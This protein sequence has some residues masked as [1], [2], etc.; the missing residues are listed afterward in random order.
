MKAMYGIEHQNGIIG[1]GL[2]PSIFFE[3]DTQGVALGW[4]ESGAL[5]LWST[6]GAVP[7]QA[8]ATPWET[9]PPMTRGPKVRPKGHTIGAGLQPSDFFG[10]FIPGRCPRLPWIGALPLR[11]KPTAAQN[12]VSTNGATPRQPGA[13]PRE[14]RNPQNSGLKARANRPAES[15]EVLGNIKALL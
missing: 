10:S 3:S 8:K 2:Q 4:H 5:P 12:A 14:N 15:A 6:K 1:S 11:N 9:N 13:T 7:S